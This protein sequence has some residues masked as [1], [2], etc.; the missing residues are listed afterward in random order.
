VT[1]DEAPKGWRSRSAWLRFLAVGV[2]AG[3]F[4]GLFGV[5]GGVLI[6]PGLLMAGLDTRLA[7]GTSLAVTVILSGAALVGYALGGSVEYLAAVLIFAGSS[8]GVVIG[9]SV[10]QRIPIK[11]LQIGFAVLLYVTA[12]RLFTSSGVATGPDDI[13]LLAV[14]GYVLLGLFAGF[15]SGILGVGGGVVL[16]PAMA[17]FFNFPQTVAKGTSLMVIVPTASLGTYRNAKYNNVY[18]EAAIVAGLGGAAFAFVGAQFA[19]NLSERTSIVLFGL[20]LVVTATQILI[21]ALRRPVEA[22]EH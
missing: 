3:F 12:V 17:V 9:T 22:K 16:V 21:G 2:L 20:L 5:G 13:T 11:P 1:V 7:H 8:V 15:L 18:F 14:I 10:L 6:V 19:D 4:A